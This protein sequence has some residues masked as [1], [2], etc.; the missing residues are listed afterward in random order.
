MA[1][2]IT[3][4]KPTNLQAL[5]DLANRAKAKIDKVGADAAAAIKSVD[6][7]DGTIL[8]FTNANKTG[9]EAFKV[10]FPKELVLDQIKTKFE[11]SFTFSSATYAG[12]T[13]PA[14]DGKPVLVVAVKGTEKGKGETTAYS[15]IDFSALVDTYSVK[16]GDSQKLLDITGY[17]VEFKISKET[18]NALE[19]KNDGLYVNISGKADKDTDAVENNLAA[20]DANGNPVD[21]GIA[22]GDV[23]TVSNI[24]TNA[25]VTAALNSVF[26]EEQAEG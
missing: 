16:A 4:Q 11:P 26:G 23:L 6:V 21:A 12:A 19:V 15:F 3:N 25:E 7:Q 22:K 13:D 17:E 24:A 5:I 2:L 8:F 10:D 9:T 20:F 1:D 18:G 14:F